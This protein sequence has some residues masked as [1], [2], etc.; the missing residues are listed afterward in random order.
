MSF[1]HKAWVFDWNTFSRELA[2]TLRRA[3]ETGDTAGLWRFLVSHRERL[4]DP[5]LGHRLGDGLARLAGAD[6]HTLGHHALTLYFDPA[7]PRICR[8]AWDAI[9]G[10]LLSDNERTALLGLP[11]GPSD[12]PFDPG[13]RGAWFQDPVMV[14]ASLTMLPALD[15]LGPYVEALR[16]AAAGGQGLYVS[17]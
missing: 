6:V 10:D 3:L 4:L 2:P 17:F 7:T 1:D 5:S 9:D 15:G 11:F 12:N 16:D 13:K 14:T 8:A